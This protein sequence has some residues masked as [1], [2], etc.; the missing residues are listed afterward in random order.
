MFPRYADI[1]IPLLREIA[2]RGGQ[3][4][5]AEIGP[6][7]KTVYEVL[8]D[9]FELSDEARN[10]VIVNSGRSKWE[11][12]VR[13]VRNDLRK[14]GYLTSPRRGIWSVTHEGRAILEE[15]EDERTGWGI[16]TGGRVLEPEAFYRAKKEAERIGELGE[17]YVLSHEKRKLNRRG[18]TDLVSKVRRVSL[19]N[20]AAG[21]D[22]LSFDEMGNEKYIEVKA[23]KSYRS[24]FELT[25]N[26]L[27]TAE[28]HRNSYWIYHIT[29]IESDSPKVVEIQNP[30]ALIENK[31]LLLK[32]TSYLVYVNESYNP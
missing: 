13:W 32:P 5:P 14:L 11:N 23:S 4:H 7:G 19:E 17:I 28:H 30:A 26:E 12:M 9:Y 21:F 6:D 22:I 18:Q 29:D 16:F 8:A 2:R 15:R 10:A 20:V 24:A 31:L 1:Q 3:T 27:K 25:A